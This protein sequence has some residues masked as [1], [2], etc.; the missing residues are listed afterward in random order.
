MTTN[1]LVTC[2]NDRPFIIQSFLIQSAKLLNH[3]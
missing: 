3:I 2:V 1:G